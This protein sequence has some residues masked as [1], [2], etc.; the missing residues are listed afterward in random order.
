MND[1]EFIAYSKV[2]NSH[3]QNI[4]TKYGELDQEKYEKNILFIKKNIKMNILD[5]IFNFAK[6]F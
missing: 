2:L 4:L 6:K 1:K 3:I 5:I